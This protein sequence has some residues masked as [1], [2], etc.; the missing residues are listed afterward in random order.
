MLKSGVKWVEVGV[1]MTNEEIAARNR[2][3]L[4]NPI[5]VSV[6]TGYSGYEEVA[7][8]DDI[9]IVNGVIVSVEEQE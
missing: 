8:P 6:V 1:Y 9:L 3:A 5:P 2:I 7:G 4:M